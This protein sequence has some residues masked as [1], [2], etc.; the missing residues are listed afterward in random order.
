MRYSS[1]FSYSM[2]YTRTYEEQ[3]EEN[4][5]PKKRFESDQPERSNEYNDS[6]FL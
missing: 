5:F 3:E 1:I 4:T 2:V 6:L